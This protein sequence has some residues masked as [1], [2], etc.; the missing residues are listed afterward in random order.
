MSFWKVEEIIDAN[1]IKVSPNWK[2]KG[3]E[4]DIIRIWGY[5]EPTTEEKIK[6]V[7]AK[8]KYILINQ[9]VELRGCQLYNPTHP[10]TCRVF[11]NTL[12]ISRY[13]PECNNF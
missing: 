2:F 5:N 1:T 4:G 10:L 12:D 8:L 13:F 6:S 7:K 9:Y 3:V 11:V